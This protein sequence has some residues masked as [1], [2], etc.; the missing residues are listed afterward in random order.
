MAATNRGRRIGMGVHLRFPP[1]ALLLLLAAACGR[2][3]ARS[4]ADAPPARGAEVVHNTGR[5]AWAPGKEWTL[6]RDLSIG[7]AGD[8]PGAFG[9]IAD[10]EVDAAGRVWVADGQAG[11]IRIFDTAGRHLRTVGRRGRGPGEFVQITGMDWAPDGRL[12]VL[13]AG[14]ARFTVFDTAGAL[15]ATHPRPGGA[16]V[17]PWPGGF[18]AQGRLHDAELAPVSPTELAQTVVRYAP[19]TRDGDALRVTD[20][21]RIPSFQPAVYENDRGAFRGVANVPFTGLRFWMLDPRG[22]VWLAITDRYRLDR[23]RLSGD[24]VTVVTRDAPPVPVTDAEVEWILQ[25]YRDFES[26]GG[27]VDRGRIPRTKPPL[28]GGFA[29]RDGTLWIVA[30]GGQGEPMLLDVFDPAGRYQGRVRADAPLAL[31][32]AP[33]VR[34]DAVYAVVRDELGVESVVRERIVRPR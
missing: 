32:P 16:A 3:D 27:R 31:T 15:V 5:G 6:R 21:L 9:R 1:C 25:A 33:V 2:A 10:V 17:V 26:R 19:V 30:A 24:T 12:W 11:E 4:P 29:A 14:A 34:G 20:S 7:G 18:D 23:A 13:D 28:Y 8:G 22:E